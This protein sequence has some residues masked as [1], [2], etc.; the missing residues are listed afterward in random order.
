MRKLQIL[1]KKRPNSVQHTQ[2]DDSKEFDHEVKDNEEFF[3]Q[4]LMMDQPNNID[5][6]D[7]DQD[8]THNQLTSSS[9]RN[10]P[11]KRFQPKIPRNRNLTN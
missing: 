10:I 11:P 2:H 6:D 7:T 8:V 5:R 9:R 1:A 3:Q 4:Y